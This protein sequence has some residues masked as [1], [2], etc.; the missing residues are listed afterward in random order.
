MAFEA[1]VFDL[2][3]TLYPASC[4]L[5]DQLAQQ[6][7]AFVMKELELEEEAA[8]ALC[9]HY[10]ATYGATLH[11]L[12][13]HHAHVDLDH[14]LT[15]VHQLQVEHF[16]Q[17]NR[18]LNTLLARLPLRKIVFTN[19]IREHAERVLRCLKIAHHFEHIFDLRSF[20]FSGKPHVESYHQVLHH[21][22]VD[23]SAVIMVEDIL[24]NL[25]PAKALGMTTILIDETMRETAGADHIVPDVVA[26]LEVAHRLVRPPVRLV[27]DGQPRTS[28]TG[29]PRL[30]KSA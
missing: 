11:G 4:G 7:G 27:K 21:L 24:A 15:S 29:A 6:I 16:V 10:Y 3:N 19:S 13:R 18:R 22:G 25:V 2:D 9:S 20:N 1:I 8:Q 23:G 5:M 26:G 14:Y 12:Q 28:R 17:P 30:R